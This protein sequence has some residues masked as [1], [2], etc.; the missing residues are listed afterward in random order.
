MEILTLLKDA[1]TLHGAFIIAL[2]LIVWFAKRLIS[3]FE[4]NQTKFGAMLDKIAD[5]H[6]GLEMDFN[7]LSGV[8]DERHGFVPRRRKSDRNG[9]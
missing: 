5:K 1:S 4:N 2:A 8:C 6:N 9:A 7:R 3:S